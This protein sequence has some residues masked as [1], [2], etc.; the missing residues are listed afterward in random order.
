MKDVE[1]KVRRTRNFKRLA[2]VGVLFGILIWGSSFL[3]LSINHF[4]KTLETKSYHDI[5]FHA[6]ELESELNGAIFATPSNKPTEF[7]R[8][9]LN[10]SV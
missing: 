3:V 4:L 8:I 7:G 9:P 6:Q 10:K 2:V 5:H 1:G